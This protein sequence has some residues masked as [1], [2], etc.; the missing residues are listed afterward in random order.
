MFKVNIYFCDDECEGA[1]ID[2]PD[3][4]GTAI[5]NDSGVYCPDCSNE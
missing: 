5:V 3:C 2:C 1:E 4:G